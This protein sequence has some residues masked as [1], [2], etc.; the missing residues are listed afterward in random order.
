[1]QKGEEQGMK[2]P[3]QCLGR[4]L[5]ILVLVTA[6][7]LATPAAAAP[8]PVVASIYP[9]ADMVHQVGGDLV[10]V[11][12]LL[13]PGASPHTFEPK[14][15]EVRQLASARLFFIIGAGLEHWADKFVRATGTAAQTVVLSKG[16]DLLPGGPDSYNIEPGSGQAASGPAGL[17]AN[18][19]IWLDPVIAGQMVEKIV[20]ALCHA[21]ASHAD[22]YHRR[23]D[24]YVHAL[25]I[26]D[27]QIRRTVATFTIRE[28]I[29]FHPAWD[30]FAR[31]YGL[32]SSGTI[33]ETP[34][35]VPTPKHIENIVAQIKKSGIR[36]VFA[37]PQLNPKVAEVVAREAGVKVLLLDPMG[38]PGLSGRGTYIHLIQT[39]LKMMKEAMQ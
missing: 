17:V 4:F 38:G 16:V 7:A 30:Y 25:K 2:T 1:V 29:S 24:T 39:N 31:R 6:A 8:L 33:E 9:V 11:T 10:A 14:P 3:I 22:V 21:D 13:P 35:R 32:K 36:A 15:S 20:S 23:A 27:A 26:L 34:G 5:S 28:F 18:P 19:H 37:E 12:T